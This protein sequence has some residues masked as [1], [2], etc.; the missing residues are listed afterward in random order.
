M[1]SPTYGGSL[2]GSAYRVLGTLVGATWAIVTWVAATAG[3]A[4]DDADANPYILGLFAFLIIAV[5]AF[6]KGG[7]PHFR[8]GSQ[9]LVAYNII[10]MAKWVNR[11]C[12]FALSSRKAR[13]GKRRGR[14]LGKGRA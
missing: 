7:T 5:A 2:L 13:L 1:S 10:V 11:A 4:W 9:I 3:G 12:T 6:I 8:L 14:S